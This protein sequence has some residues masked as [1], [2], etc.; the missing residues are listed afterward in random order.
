MDNGMGNSEAGATL[1]HASGDLAQWLVDLQ[2]SIVFLTRLPIRVNAGHL[3][4][5]APAARAFAAV[6]AI[7]GAMAAVA[8]YALHAA[9]VPSGVAVAVMLG[10][11][12]M[13]TGGLH[14]DGLADMAD[15]FGAGATRERC[16]EIMR[17]SRIGSYGVLAVVM[18]FIIRW[19][20]FA[21]IAASDEGGGW[22][23]AGVM[24]A[25]AGLSRAAMV[26]VLFALPP[27]RLE[28]RS[29][30]AGR[31]GRSTLMQANALGL[32]IFVVALW[33]LASLWAMT[34][35][36]LAGLIAVLAVI[37]LSRRHIGG[38]TGDVCG[39]SQIASE[40][41]MIVA[42]SAVTG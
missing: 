1:D 35:T 41:A 32:A 37:A 38:Q 13:L 30:E 9:G 34:I 7:L 36:A 39:G 23:L 20:A 24:I 5:L 16:L 26:A 31:P 17:D 4:P 33:P 40:L 25:V 21:H 14:E 11:G 10:I 18:A 27:A 6:G 8:Y 22:T 2:A 3:P 12:V 42:A 28:G 15:G 29:A 19:A